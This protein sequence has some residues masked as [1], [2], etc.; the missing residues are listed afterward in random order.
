MVVPVMLAM[1]L[2][3]Y[4][5]GRGFHA[6]ISVTNGARHAARVAMHDDKACVK[7]DLASFAQGGASPYAVTFTDPVE[8]DGLCYVTVSYAYTPIVPFV[9]NAFDLPGLGTVGPLWD[10]VMSE[11]AV[12]KVDA[13]SVSP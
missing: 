9:T 2:V 12:S 10:G 6:Y 7:A 5:F 13:K 8:S 1:L 11:T 4:D 3:V